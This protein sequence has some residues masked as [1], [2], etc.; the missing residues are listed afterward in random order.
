MKKSLVA[1][2]GTAVLALALAACGNSGGGGGGGAASTS[3]GTPKAGGNLVMARADEVQSLVPW[4]PTD[5][6]SIWTLEEIYDTLL[7]PKPDGH[8]VE[9]S[10]ATSW[11][12]S[13]DK[14]S[15][16]FHLRHGVK[17]SNGQPLTSADVKF[18]LEQASKP[19]TP[20]YFIDQVMKSF[21]TP[22]PYTVVITTR[23]PW[24]PLPA[25]VA[26]FANSIVPDN[27]GGE[28]AAQFAQHPIGSGPFML[29]SWIKG[30]S[31][32]LVKNP[33]Y[34]QPGKPYLNSVTFT[35]VADANTR[36]TQIQS[37]QAQIDEFPAY[38][39]ISALNAGNTKVGIFDSSRVDYFV[40]NTRKEPFTDPQVRLAVNQA[41][42]RAALVKTVQFGYGT[43]AKGYMSPVLWA[44]DPSIAPPAYDLSAAKADLA[45]SKYPNGFSTT[46]TV[47]AGND[48]Q[49]SAAQLIQAS[50][51]QIGIKATIA[52]LDPSALSTAQENGNFSMSFAYQ[53]T[54]I[55]DPDEIIRFAGLYDGGSNTMYSGYN[56]TELEAMANKA[57]TL[58]DQPA[59]QQIY[60]QI[61]ETVNHA[62]PY[63]ALYYSPS[64]YAHGDGVQ[65]FHPYPTGNYNLV[66]TWLSSS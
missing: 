59:R 5:N 22:D 56:D 44:Y 4:V 19:N 35:V 25:D 8:G 57:D 26:L 13:A 60:D 29:S 9:A 64:V 10:V 46:I 63:A 17:F 48:N 52:T 66:D 61:Q 65:D 39:S 31:I 12:Q 16:T 45:K 6:A 43:P 30:Q 47:A 33:H 15:W 42:D 18:S 55:V 2:A 62:N 41:I 49:Q 1:A 32:K 53:T 14:L 7:V 24:S 3:A 38:S 34:W 27:Y 37:G 20:F 54:D 50:L 11:S 58:S 28:T 21:A 51:A 23:Q 36:A 40:M